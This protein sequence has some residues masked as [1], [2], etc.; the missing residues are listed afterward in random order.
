MRSRDIRVGDWNFPCPLTKRA[1]HSRRSPVNQ[2]GECALQLEL[3]QHVLWKWVRQEYGPPTPSKSSAPN[4]V[5][6]SVSWPTASRTS[7]VRCPTRCCPESNV[8]SG[9]A[10]ST[11]SSR[12]PKHSSSHPSCCW[13]DRAP[14]ET[15]HPPPLIEH[16]PPSKDPSLL[17]HPPD[18]PCPRTPSAPNGW[19]SCPAPSLPSRGDRRD[20]RLLGLVGQGPRAPAPD[21]AHASRPRLPI[22]RGSPRRD[23]PHPRGA[24]AT[25]S[26]KDAVTGQSAGVGYGAVASDSADAALHDLRPTSQGPTAPQVPVRHCRVVLP[27]TSEKGGDARRGLRREARQLLAR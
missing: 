8:P 11:T 7:A 15:G 12:S 3:W 5:S 16:P 24:G 20:P 23:H 14:P 18:A 21:T 6:P 19:R 10:T 13:R 26:P 17:P 1:Q 2:T 27:G 22:H 25:E 9:V 4:A